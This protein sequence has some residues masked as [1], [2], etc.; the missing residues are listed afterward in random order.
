[1]KRGYVRGS[2]RA[3]PKKQI[4]AMKAAGIE[5][6]YVEGEHE[7]VN[8]FIRSLREGDEAVVTTLDRLAKRRSSLQEAINGIHDRGAVI[9]ELETGMRSDN[10]D[11]LANMI[12]SAANALAR[13]GTAQ[14]SKVAML[15]GKKGGRPV[16][17]DRLDM[18]AA[19]REWFDVRH[20]TVFDALLAMPGWSMRSA[21]REFGRRNIGRPGPRGKPRY[22][23]SSKAK[24]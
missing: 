4:D 5:V 7:T 10:R 14:Q 3:K 18:K 17:T 1:M 6:V 15:N 12:F 22:T 16:N 9:V 13:D 8:D 19:E 21:Y 11:Q 2:P 24:S 23:K 20:E